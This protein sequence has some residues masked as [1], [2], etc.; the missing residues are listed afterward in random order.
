MSRV[1][2]GLLLALSLLVPQ[3]I[4]AS[5]VPPAPTAPPIGD[6]HPPRPEPLDPTAPLLL[7]VGLAV[8]GTL[9]VLRRR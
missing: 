2:L 8:T 9:G 5:L 3:P 1:L 4:S 6:P 7:V